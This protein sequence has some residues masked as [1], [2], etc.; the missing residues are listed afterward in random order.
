VFEGKK[1]KIKTHIKCSTRLLSTTEYNTI[2]LHNQKEFHHYSTG[3]NNDKHE[4][5]L[6]NIINATRPPVDAIYCISVLNIK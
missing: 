5:N 3:S 6:R 4:D 2:Q 1:C